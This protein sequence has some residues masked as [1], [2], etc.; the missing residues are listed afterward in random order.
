MAQ[1][2]PLEVARRCAETAGTLI[3]LTSSDF[4][5]AGLSMPEELYEEA[6]KSW[7]AAP[8]YRPSGSGSTTARE[9]VAAFL[10]ADGLPTRPEQIILTAGSSISYQLLFAALAPQ[11]TETGDHRTVGLPSPAYPLF[12]ELCR[13]VGLDPDWY[14][15]SDRERYEPEITSVEA[16]L[17]GHPRALVI[18]SPNNPTGA[19]HSSESLH[20]IVG[21]A[22]RAGVVVVSDE[23]FS[24]FRSDGDLPRAAVHTGNG[25]PI[26]ATLNGLSK[27]CAAPELKLGWIALHGDQAAVSTLADSIDTLHDAL[28]TVSGA[29]EAFAGVFLSRDASAARAAIADGI[30]QRRKTL[31]RAFPAVPGIRLES[32]P[33][34]VHTILEIATETA[35]ER[36]GT[37]D[38]ETL[39]RRILEASGVHLHP[40]YLYGLRP[41]EGSIDPRFIVSCVHTC[42]TLEEAATRLRG[43]LG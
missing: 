36:F 37:I 29:A 22:D 11:P 18:I 25:G 42:E 3:D 40:G 24:A 20:R 28:L 41:R 27:L 7:R 1:P 26:V 9:A 8:R 34:G 33:G 13:S 12:E 4:R 5:A 19:I 23:V 39:A 38:D 15:L 30:A 17:I 10:T 21:A 6:W 2:T 16:V 43:I 14:R 32:S 35:A 31:H